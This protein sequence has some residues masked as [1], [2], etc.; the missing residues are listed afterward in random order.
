MQSTRRFRDQDV[1]RVRNLTFNIPIGDGAQWPSS[2]APTLQPIRTTITIPH[3]LRRA[4][5]SDDI[6]RSLNYGSLSKAV[7]RSL[8]AHS[9]SGFASLEALLDHIFH[10]VFA[11]FEEIRQVN[12]EIVKPRALPYAA[13]VGIVST[14]TRDGARVGADVYFLNRLGVNL[15]VGLNQCERED[16]Q[17]VEFDIEVARPS[18]QDDVFSFRS[19]GKVIREV[20]EASSFISLESLASLVAQTTLHHLGREDNVA[21]VRAA[22]PKAITFAEAAE[23]ELLRTLADYQDSVDVSVAVDMHPLGIKAL[24]ANIENA[25]RMLERPDD[26]VES[27][28]GTSAPLV[29]VI[30]TSFLYETAPMYV[31]DQPR[32]V[33]GACMIET[34]LSARTLLTLLKKI[35]EAV[36]RV[37]SIRNGPRAV[38]LDIVF[39]DNSVI[40]TRPETERDGL[41]NLQGQLVV[42][43]PRMAEREFVLRPLNE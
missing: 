36:G 31:T 43:H 42:P 8:D 26:F 2:S 24:F 29:Y 30:D 22:K 41:D 37:P 6:A 16:K 35:E 19:L 38:D 32:F 13:G 21:T 10:T 27:P 34:N 40:D 17:L 18:Q 5:R 4:A 28:E 14:R 15:I 7:V 9:A 20:T 33:N 1:V 11:A 3:D 12:V 23:V 25:M 39:Y